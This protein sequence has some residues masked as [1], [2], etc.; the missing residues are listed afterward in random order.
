MSAFNVLVK[1]SKANFELHSLPHSLPHCTHL[2][3]FG[4]AR[5]IVDFGGHK[6]ELVFLRQ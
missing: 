2:L 4:E 5:L 6:V 3:M 1:F